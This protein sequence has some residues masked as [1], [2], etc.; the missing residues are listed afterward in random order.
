MAND[1]SAGQGGTS[2][3]PRMSPFFSCWGY[4]LDNLLTPEENA[5]VD[6]YGATEILD[7]SDSERC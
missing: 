7:F 1:F 3:A 2:G 4:T 6:D 5:G